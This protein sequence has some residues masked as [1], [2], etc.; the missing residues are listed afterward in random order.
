MVSPRSATIA[1]TSRGA[2]SK[3]RKSFSKISTPSKPAAAIA[4]SFSRRSPLI[5][6]VAIE[7]CK[8]RPP[9]HT[10]QSYELV[11][12]F[13]RTLRGLHS[14]ATD[15]HQR[16]SRGRQQR[17]ISVSSN[18]RQLVGP[19]HEADHHVDRLPAQRR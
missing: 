16:S 4:S 15:R 2:R 10:K 9:R 8:I 7:V 18:V 11:S 5:D 14:H 12:T 6:T 17:H 13:T 1:A 19:Q 3:A